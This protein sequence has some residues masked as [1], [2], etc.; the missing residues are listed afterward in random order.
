MKEKIINDTV[1]DNEDKNIITA[2]N[3]IFDYEAESIEDAI[4][5]TCN[6]LEKKKYIASS[7]TKS[8]LDILKNHTSYMIIHNGIILPHAKNDANVFKTSGILI[9]LK[10]I[11]ELNE[12]KIKYI[13]TFAIKD[14]EKELNKV[15]KIINK[16]FKDKMTKIMKTRD[17]HKIVEYFSKNDDT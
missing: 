10:N 9:E 4:K 3:I 5:Y 7:Y 16:I 8:I 17:K 15:S 14:K 2:Q 12:N 1:E 6:I 11:L 13:F